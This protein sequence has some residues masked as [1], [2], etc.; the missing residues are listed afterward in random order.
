MLQPQV[1]ST[2]NASDAKAV[3]H[4]AV[5]RAWTVLCMVSDT[6]VLVV[7]RTAHRAAPCCTDLSQVGSE[8]ATMSL[9]L[10]EACS[11]LCHRRHRGKVAVVVCSTASVL[12][13][14]KWRHGRATRQHL[15]RFATQALDAR[16]AFHA[17][18]QALH[19]KQAWSA[20]AHSAPLTTTSISLPN[21][22]GWCPDEQMRQHPYAVLMLHILW[23]CSS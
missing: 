18:A 16:S 15:C 2:L 11:V 1:Y 19:C 7:Q 22:L 3:V 6:R 8:S 13:H 12:Q 4:V 5:Q 9:P 14:C 10:R 21:V 20:V 17:S 23:A